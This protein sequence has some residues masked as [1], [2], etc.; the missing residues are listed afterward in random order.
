MTES[1]G[2]NENVNDF[3]ITKRIP[4]VSFDSVDRQILNFPSNFHFCN[5]A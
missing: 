1:V 4:V 2:N 3:G 5:T